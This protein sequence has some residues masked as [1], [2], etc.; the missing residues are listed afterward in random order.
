[1]FP[2]QRDNL[3]CDQYLKSVT[4]T[5][6]QTGKNESLLLV[7]NLLPSFYRHVTLTGTE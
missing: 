5:T 1:M 7:R 3:K 4:K 2:L 6:Q